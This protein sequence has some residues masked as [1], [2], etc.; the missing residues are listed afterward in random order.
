MHAC[1]R[2][3]RVLPGAVGCDAF[4]VPKRLTIRVSQKPMFGFMLIFLALFALM[5]APAAG[6]VV[7][8][9]ALGILIIGV[10]AVMMLLNRVMVVVIAD[11]DGLQVRNF[12]WS[13]RLRWSEVED[14]RLTEERN[15]AR[16]FVLRHG[17]AP[18]VPLNATIRLWPSAR[19]DDRLD[20]QLGQ[21]RDW[22]RYGQ[23]Q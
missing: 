2:L 22:V 21:L 12:I 14:V 20:E 19:D 13:Q 16:L 10:F 7:F 1:G 3:G 8:A 9:V 23:S 4:A 15:A 11:A 6:R 5:A 17:A 18:M